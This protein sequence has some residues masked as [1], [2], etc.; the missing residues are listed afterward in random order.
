MKI[1]NDKNIDKAKIILNTHNID[2]YIVNPTQ[3]IME[4]LSKI[5]INE[6]LDKCGYNFT[7]EQKSELVKNYY[8]ELYNYL[9]TYEDILTMDSIFPNSIEY[10]RHCGLEDDIKL[11][12]N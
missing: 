5:M 8:K 4:I 2:C 9:A 3:H 10:L 1:L 7:L 12:S 6:Y 11:L